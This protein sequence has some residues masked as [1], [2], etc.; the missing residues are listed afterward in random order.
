VPEV[1]VILTPGELKDSK[2]ENEIMI[3]IDTLRAST[4]I[5]TALAS[6]IEAVFP[7]S[8]ES[9]LRDYYMK[10]QNKAKYILAGEFEG[11]PIKGFDF[12]N[13]PLIFANNR[14]RKRIMLLKTSNGTKVLDQISKNN[15]VLIGGLVNSMKIVSMILDK[16][17][18]VYLVCAGSN[19]TFSLEDFFG[20]GRY[21]FLLREAG[22]KGDVLTVAAARIYEDN[23]EYED[24]VN[25]FY[26][27]RNGQNLFDLGYEK[28][29][30]FSSKVDIYDIAPVFD[31]KKIIRGKSILA[32]V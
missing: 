26:H 20:A 4:T 8:T 7:F 29:I 11:K 12:G 19:G 6:G 28:D 2:I 32:M 22:W 17:D 13:S 18:D 21:C 1:K 5:V 15:L 25:L 14:F 27:S 30:K 31:G 23:S 9:A 16:E 10:E 24:I 3:V